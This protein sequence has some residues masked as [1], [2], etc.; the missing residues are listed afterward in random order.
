LVVA[1]DD[2]AGREIKMREWMCIQPDGSPKMLIVTEK[3]PNLCREF[4]R[5]KKKIVNGYVQDEGNR[6]A[7]CHAIETLEYAV[8][9]G[10][11][12]VKPKPNVVNK[13]RVAM[14]IAQRKRR[15][16]Q[17]RMN[18]MMR[19]GGSASNYISLGPTGE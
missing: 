3:C 5:F 13:S 1:C 19:G 7:N 4:S 14:I 6:R 17:R 10:L 9:H 12:Y 8:A 11:K 16:S 15:S 2:V 18:Q